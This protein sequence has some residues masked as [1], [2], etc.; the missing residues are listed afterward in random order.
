M[1]YPKVFPLLFKESWLD[2]LNSGNSDSGS[3]KLNFK[4][5]QSWFLSAPLLH[6]VYSKLRFWS[7]LKLVV[8]LEELGFFAICYCQI[9]EFAFVAIRLRYPGSACHLGGFSLFKGVIVRSEWIT[10]LF[11]YM[12]SVGDFINHF[13]KSQF[14]SHYRFWQLAPVPHWLA[15]TSKKVRPQRSFES[16]SYHPLKLRSLRV[17]SKIPIGLPF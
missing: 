15:L 14:F 12:N 2:L 7:G 11:Q 10:T 6:I 8:H 1:G 5:G 4:P 13:S 16:F 9:F 3:E 17:R